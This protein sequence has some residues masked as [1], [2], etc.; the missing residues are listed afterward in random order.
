M[1]SNYKSAM[2]IYRKLL[3]QQ[4]QLCGKRL[5]IDN[6]GESSTT[7]IADRIPVAY[8]CVRVYCVY[9]VAVQPTSS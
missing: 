5:R 8:K 3:E 4:W 9:M 2:N 6:Y 7:S 1:K